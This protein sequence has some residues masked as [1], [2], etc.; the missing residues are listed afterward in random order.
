[1]PRAARRGSIAG[2]RPRGPVIARPNST[3]RST[4]W[5]A[6]GA[7]TIHQCLSEA[8]PDDG[9]TYAQ[10]GTADTLEVGL[11]AIPT[12]S[13]RSAHLVRIRAARSAGTA[14]FSSVQLRDGATVI[15]TIPM[16]YGAD[17][18]YA[19]TTY[20][21]TSAEAGDITNYADLRIV[22]TVNNLASNIRITHMELQV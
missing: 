3:I 5:S 18:A 15:A 8:V 16:T 20:G 11:S 9:A 6:N 21:L 4:N 19:T 2:S 7:P 13:N 22:A 12:P 17:N 1:M 10:C 14:T